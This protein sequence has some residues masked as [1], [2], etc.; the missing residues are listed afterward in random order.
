MSG[1]LCPLDTHKKLAPLGSLA[2]ALPPKST[3]EI[4]SS[5]PCRLI[6]RKLKQGIS[7]FQEKES[8]FPHMQI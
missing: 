8:N 7:F 2:P 5:F 1:T 6:P 4:V 3:K